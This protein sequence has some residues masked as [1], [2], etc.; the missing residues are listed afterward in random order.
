MNESQ[1]MLLIIIA[2]F[3]FLAVGGY[4]ME[5]EEETPAT[6]SHDTEHEH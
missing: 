2:I 3:V 5:Q 4:L 6:P 1:I